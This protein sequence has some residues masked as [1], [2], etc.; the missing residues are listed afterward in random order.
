MP[1]YRF[2]DLD[3]FAGP[4]GRG[5]PLA[6]VVAADDWS[7]DAMQAFAAWTER[8]ETT[9]LLTPTDA[10]ADYR[11]R[12]F[13]PSREIAFAGH[14]SIG[15]A[16]AFLETQPSFARR[17]TLLQQCA[18]GLIPIA[19]DGK[20]SARTLSFR[21][22]ALR[23]VAPTL[24]SDADLAALLAAFP[25][26]SSALVEGGRRWCLAALPDEPTLR[27]WH[28]D[29][30]RIRALAARHDALGLAAYARS[31]SPEFEL[32][33]RAFPLGVG[34]DEDPASGAA[35]GLIAGYLGATGAFPDLA[36]GYRVSQ[37]REIGRDAR[38]VIRYD[39]SGAAF[40]GGAVRGVIDGRVDF[41]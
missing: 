23:I 28:P 7:D 24:D 9:F 26:A 16:H 13:T 3:V 12:I 35:N 14:P 36:R 31:A 30:T 39:E 8:V 22:P 37:G 33:V 21:A 20:E 10:T 27:A 25:R 5:N 19:I 41:G 15:T 6:V 34:I 2:F 4:R 17:G 38:L 40:V 11:V 32:V 1:M 18:A 29:R